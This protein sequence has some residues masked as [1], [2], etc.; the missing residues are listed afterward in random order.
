MSP[1]YAGKSAD[2]ILSVSGTTTT[3]AEKRFRFSA[4]MLLPVLVVVAFIAYLL[5]KRRTVRTTVFST[6]TATT[7]D[8]RIDS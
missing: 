3:N 2:R 1:F 8:K 6:P 4:W 5:A 7:V